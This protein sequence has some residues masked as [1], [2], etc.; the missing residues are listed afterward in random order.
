MK[1]V[2]FIIILCISVAFSMLNAQQGSRESFYYCQDKKIYLQQKTNLIFLK[3]TPNADRKQIENIINS[4]IELQPMLGANFDD[5]FSI[6][7]VLEEK[8]GENISL[9]TIETFKTNPYV[10]FATSLFEYNNILQVLTDE[11]VVKLKPSTSYTQLQILAENN[12]CNI[13]EENQFVQNQYII[14]VPKISDLNALQMSNLFYETGL[15][16]FSEPNFLILNAYNSSDT[17]FVDQ[18]GLKN[19]G[20]YGGIYGIDIKSEQA[21]NITTGLG[22]KVALI[23]DGVDLTHPDL[24]ANLLPGYEHPSSGYNTG[25]AAVWNNENHGTACAGIIGAIKDNGIGISGVA[26]NCKIIPMRINGWGPLFNIDIAADGI[27]W[28]WQNGADVIN[29]SWG[30]SSPN[31]P[32]INA[33]NNA[34]TQGRNGNGCIVVCASGNN[35]NAVSFPAYLPNVISVGAMSPCGERKRSSSNSNEVGSGVLTDLVGVSCDSET[36]WG[37]NYGTDLDVV[38]PGVL[39]STTDRRG[40]ISV[41]PPILFGYNPNTPIH[42]NAGGNIVSND[43][44][45]TD[46]TVWFNG[47]SAS[48]P[49]VSAVAALILSVNPNLTWQQVMDIIEST[50]QKIRPDLYAYSTTSGRPNGTWNNEV[51]YGLVDA[52]SAVNAAQDTISKADLLIRDDLQDN[53][54]EPN[55]NSDYNYIKWNSPDIGLADINHQPITNNLFP[56]MTTVYVRVKIRN[57][58]TQASTGH[59]KLYLYWSMSSLGSLWNSS[60]TGSDPATSGE[61]T[62]TQ[63]VNVPALQPG[64]QS[65]PLDVLWSLPDYIIENNASLNP[66]FGGQMSWGFCILARVDDGNDTFGVNENSLATITFAINSNNVAVSNGNNVIYDEYC[67]KVVHLNV[68]TFGDA[69]TSTITFNQLSR[70]DRYVLNDFA[71]LYALLSN[72]LMEKLDVNS[73]KDIKV[74]DQNRVFLT[75]ANSELHFAP[76]DKEDEKYFIGAEVHFI[77]D[78]MPELNEFDFDLTYQEN[79]KNAE[80]M[81]FTAVRDENIYFKAHAEVNNPKVVKAKEEV[82][83][84]ANQIIADAKYIWHDEADNIIGEG[85]QITLIPDYSQTYKIEIEQKDNGY[86]SYDEVQVIVVDGVIKSLA[87]NPANDYVTVTYLL[88]DNA[89]DASIQV[90][91]IYGNISASYPLQISMT[92]QQIPLSGLMPGTYLVKLLISGTAVDSKNLLKQ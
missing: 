36:K 86:K 61:I 38:A 81:R 53:G 56:N 83:L 57:I 48:C 40:S 1:K 68:G 33:I 45:N 79:G 20:Q 82:T 11:F 26:P 70:S 18:W 37:S 90:S 25:G 27:N 88:S 72:D 39:I 22:V 24:V 64:E 67:C 74:I 89:T 21:W 69:D 46:Y 19:T 59:E 62:T 4:D 43:Y 78:K 8:N 14:K 7:A 77:S 9:T 44:A 50:A 75:S 10:I 92:K 5:C 2:I 80:S 85:Y 55:N 29:C 52:Y 23:D 42:L 63:G 47:T 31:T 87:P 3:F 65:V 51:G 28:A 13:G 41:N 66:L 91:D 35:N 30:G 54:T 12:N 76:L 15:F 58:G 17:Y 6:Y 16:D 60:W 34:V 84:T 49:Q 32:T 71:E 73:S